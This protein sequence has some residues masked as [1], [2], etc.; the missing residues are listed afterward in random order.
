MKNK[1]LFILHLPPPVH[2]AAMVGEYI[3][4]SIEVNSKFDC[5]YINLSTSKTVDD[6]GKSSF[7]KYFTFLRLYINVL[8]RIFHNRFDLC[9]ITI[10]SKGSGF[11]KEMVIVAIVKLF[12]IPIVYHYHNK[13]IAENCNSWLKKMLYRFQLSK[14][15]TILLSSQLY[16]DIENFLPIDRLYYCPNGTPLV[17]QT[18]ITIQKNRNKEANILFLSNMM[19]SKGVYVF[20]EACKILLAKGVVFK[21]NFVGSWGDIK[22]LDFN[23]YIT[24][25]KLSEV[26]SYL[27]VKYDND[28]KEVLKESNIFVSPTC[29]DCFPLVL[30]EA[31][32]YRLPI[33][34]TNEGAIPEIVEDGVNGFIVP[35]KDAQTLA[36]KIKYLIR[37]PEIAQQMGESGY[38]KYVNNYTLDIFEKNFISTISQVIADFKKE[39]RKVKQRLKDLPLFILSLGMLP[40]DKCLVNTINAH[41]FNTLQKDFDFYESLQKSTILLPDG[42]SI[43]LAIRLLTGKKIGKI[44]GEDLFKWEME[45]MEQERGKVFFLGSSEATL[46]KIV[47]RTKRE[48]PNVMVATYSPPYKPEFTAEDNQQM[49]EAVN[50]FKPDV[51]LIGMTAPKQEKWAA[52]HFEQLM[53][54]HVC[55]IGAVFDFYAGTVKRAPR[56]MIAIGMEW[57]YR[58]VREPRRMWRRYLIGNALFIYYIIC[59]KLK[60]KG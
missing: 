50:A 56:W 57:F 45:R 22:Q 32:Q 6:I 33:V 51:L 58:L 2:G 54:T 11:Y 13:G 35:K 37:N 20:L 42:I 14:S 16:S 36:D 46:A 31:M 23:S 17:N 34:T 38:K 1:I 8:I 12:R 26:V 21:A 39:K 47:E 19:V 3:K 41:S 49:I 24:D 25:N 7:S 27:G 60:M 55:S 28:K 48:Y 52:A 53:A 10:N 59:E 40:K 29:N 4:D 44:A 30:L 43:V 18:D 15:R 5:T 9:Y